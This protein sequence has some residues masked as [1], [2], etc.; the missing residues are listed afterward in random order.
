M[1]RDAIID[2]DEETEV[3]HIEFLSEFEDE[4]WPIYQRRGLTKDTALLAWQLNNIQ[5][6]LLRIRDAV[7]ED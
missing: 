5:N 7:E 3:S 6:T 4:V 1:P 2:M